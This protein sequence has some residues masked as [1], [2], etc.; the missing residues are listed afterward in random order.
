MPVR[1]LTA[2]LGLALGPSVIAFD[3]D[4]TAATQL[5]VVTTP[6]W[7]STEGRFH[8]FERRESGWQP[9]LPQAAVSIGRSGYGWG[10]GLHDAQ[11]GPQKREGDGRSPAGV[12]ALGE[13]FGYPAAVTT[14]LPYRPMDVSHW[15]VDVADSP[16]YNRIVSTRDV[17][18]DAVAGA[19]EPM[20]RDIHLD[21]DRRYRLGFVVEHNPQQVPG[22]GSCIFFHLWEETLEATIGCTAFA[23]DDMERLLAWLDADARPLLVALPQDEYARL[24]TSWG[25]PPLVL[26]HPSDVSSEHESTTE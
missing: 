19:T 20:R 9:A 7:E 6:G 11:P 3:L 22:A 12:F 13:A 15:C 26:P 17:G 25:L 8:A 2:L 1:L 14:G 16:L 10:L 23:D 5:L 18:T 24:Q 21:G 4:R